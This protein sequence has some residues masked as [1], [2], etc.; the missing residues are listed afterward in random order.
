ML[1]WEE[2][3]AETKEQLPQNVASNKVGDLAQ[4]LSGA[5]T[6][7]KDDYPQ[8]R[9]EDNQAKGT[10]YN[11]KPLHKAKGRNGFPNL[12]KIHVHPTTRMNNERLRRGWRSPAFYLCAV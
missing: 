11:G 10:K 1:M 3:L 4:S 7:L 9:G 6:V 12:V 5:I 2:K 8:D